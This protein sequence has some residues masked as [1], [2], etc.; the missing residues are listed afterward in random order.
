[1]CADLRRGLSGALCGLPSGEHPP[2]WPETFA[3]QTHPI[4][5]G[6]P[7]RER[8]VA[9]LRVLPCSQ[10]MQP[11]GRP[12]CPGG[13][14]CRFMPKRGWP[15]PG[16]ECPCRWLPVLGHR[17]CSSPTDQAP[18]YFPLCSGGS[19]PTPDPTL[20]LA[21]LRGGSPT[22]EARAG[23]ARCWPWTH[24]SGRFGAFISGGLP[25]ICPRSAGGQ[26]GLHLLCPFPLLQAPAC[27]P[28]WPRPCWREGVHWRRRPSTSPVLPPRSAP[29]SCVCSPE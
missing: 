13:P 10:T 21:V 3:R 17:D 9:A 12:W 6:S 8:A 5:P 27:S 23:R 2:P 11:E 28:L 29:F 16:W 19:F 20:S 15:P 26:G 18:S 4:Q 24:F 1:M 14:I 22:G 7:S 25:P